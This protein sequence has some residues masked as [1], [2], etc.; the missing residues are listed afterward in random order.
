MFLELR[1]RVSEPFFI[2]LESVTSGSSGRNITFKLCD[3]HLMHIQGLL[4][5]SESTRLN[6]V[7]MLGDLGA[8]AEALLRAVHFLLYLFSFRCVFIGRSGA[9]RREVL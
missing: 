9:L 3:D 7:Y 1:G 5:S 8:Y 4:R 2:F 6:L